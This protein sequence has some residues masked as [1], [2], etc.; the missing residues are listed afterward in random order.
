[1]IPYIKFSDNEESYFI[2][3]LTNRL[4]RYL[5]R[6]LNLENVIQY[7]IRNDNFFVGI[8]CKKEDIPIVVQKFEEEFNKR[9]LDKYLYIESSI[10]ITF[11]YKNITLEEY[12]AVLKLLSVII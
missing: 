11:K 7:Y 6:I 5:V 1:M 8:S 4:I 2:F 9:G 10:Y 3:N 12:M